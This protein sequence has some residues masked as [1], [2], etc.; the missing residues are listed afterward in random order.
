TEFLIPFRSTCFPYFYRVVATGSS[1]AS[2]VPN[3]TELDIHLCK[4]L[5][6]CNMG[7][8]NQVIHLKEQR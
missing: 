4:S 7:I 1:N 8:L 3:Q 5:Y 6:T 2:A